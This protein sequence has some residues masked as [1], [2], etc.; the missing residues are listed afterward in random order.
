M[1]KLLAIFLCLVMLLSVFV[2]CDEKDKKKNDENDDPNS[3]MQSEID[4][5]LA[6][7]GE[8]LQTVPYKETEKQT[9]KVKVFVSGQTLDQNDTKTTYYQWD[10]N[11]MV[12]YSDK[13]GKDVTMIYYNGVF[14]VPTT[15]KK[16]PLSAKE[17]E[18]AF[19]VA[20]FDEEWFDSFKFKEIKVTKNDNGTTTIFGKGASE[21]AA[22]TASE[23]LGEVGSS[24]GMNITM[25][26]DSMEST[27]TLD[28]EGALIRQDYKVSFSADVKLDETTM[29]MS[30]TILTECTYAYGEKY[31][32]SAPANLD[33]FKT[34]SSIDDLA[35]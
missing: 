9:Q 2:S 8:K 11:N 5:L 17:V 29:S 20:G 10:G 16:F 22:A 21:E 18:E 13:Y 26:Y 1:K 19:G 31:K 3:A 32:V 33:E 34:A 14:Y 23:I 6:V 12:S 30:G 28:A 15:M 4:A 7:A 24:T 25:D 27:L 35:G